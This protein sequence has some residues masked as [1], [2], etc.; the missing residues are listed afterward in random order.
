[1]IKKNLL[2]VQSMYEYI[3]GKIINKHVL[4]STV[5]RRINYRFAFY[6]L[7]ED[8]FDAIIIFFNKKEHLFNK[9]FIYSISEFD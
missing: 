2:R 7:V 1:M 8:L 5:S 6:C 3:L 9:K 4:V